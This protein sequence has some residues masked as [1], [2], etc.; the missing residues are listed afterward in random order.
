[1]KELERSKST[2]ASNNE[3]IINV[4][5]QDTHLCKS[6]PPSFLD[7]KSPSPSTKCMAQFALV[8]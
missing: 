5:L 2:L 3:L 7:L 8:K 6:N 4:N 1:M